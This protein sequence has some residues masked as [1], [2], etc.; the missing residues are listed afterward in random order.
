MAGFNWTTCEIRMTASGGVY[1][2]TTA[3]LAN[4]PSDADATMSFSHEYVHFLQLISSLSGLRLLGELIDLGVKG[5]LILS[6]HVEGEQIMVRHKMLPLLAAQADHA[7]VANPIF[8]PRLRYLNEQ[9][10]ILFSSQDY[11]YTG[12]EPAWSLVQQVV[13]VGTYTEQFIGIVTPRATFRPITPGML[14][15]GMARRIDQLLKTNEGFAH[16]DWAN[17]EIEEE[18]YNGI[19]NVLSQADYENN[20]APATVQRLT[21]V[22]C[23]LALG[24]IRPDWA[25]AVM[26]GRLK[27]NRSAGGLVATI[28]ITLRDL[29]MSRD[30]DLLKASTFNEVVEDLQ[31][32]AGNVIDRTEYLPIYAQLKNIHRAGN[33]VFAHPEYFADESIGWGHVREWMSMFTVPRVVADDGDVDS[34]DGV[35][36]TPTVTDFLREIV[37]V[38]S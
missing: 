20:V 23:W 9:A 22:L 8:R 7:G 38:F 19:F 25:M 14:A 31:H 36:C 32:G 29:L 13:T 10:S 30:V 24:S 11:P 34:I 4:I 37:R 12:A 16:H 15:E 2:G 35:E 17:N 3:D 6:G 1:H 28:A 33:L 5:T 26:L 27:E 18:F 21:I